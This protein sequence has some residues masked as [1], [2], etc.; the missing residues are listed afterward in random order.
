[1]PPTPV[2]WDGPNGDGSFL[3]AEVNEALREIFADRL[4]EG[5]GAEVN[6]K[7]DSANGNAS[8]ASMGKPKK[9]PASAAAKAAKMNDTDRARERSPRRGAA[10]SSG[11]SSSAAAGGANGFNGSLP[12]IDQQAVAAAREQLARLAESDRERALRRAQGD[13]ER[14]LRRAQ[15]QDDDIEAGSADFDEVDIKRQ[16]KNQA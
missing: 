12:E 7:P 15:E 1:M 16:K 5:L 2:F 14:A 9:S 3:G 13:R 4:S 10:A 11:S 6:A 8:N